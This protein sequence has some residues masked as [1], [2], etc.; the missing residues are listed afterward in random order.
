[1]IPKEPFVKSKAF[2][3]TELL[4][5]IAIAPFA[6][7]QHEGGHTLDANG[8]QAGHSTPTAAAVSARKLVGSPAPAFRTKD[9]GGKEVSLSSLRI[10]PTVLVF[11]EKGCPCCKSGK[12]FLDRI[13]NRYRDVAN[14]VGV[15]YGD[16]S[17]ASSWQK[18]TTPQFR[19]LSD[20]GGKIA[21][22]YHAETGLATRLIGKDG[23]IVLAY[24]GYSAP[25]LKELSA[26][27]ALL[28]GVADRKMDTRPA[29]LEMTSGCP[30]GMGDKMKV[31]GGR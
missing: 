20:P 5:V 7:P 17:D 18:L 15:V 27:I 12:P 26:Q 28:A 19:V 10:R 2:T 14:V 29:P 1:V 6:L 21:K 22:E 3:L 4:A 8:K 24:P 13:Q 23:K 25:M 16:I 9:S 11:I 31:G 30:L